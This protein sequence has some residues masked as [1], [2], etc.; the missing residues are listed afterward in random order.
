VIQSPAAIDYHSA[1]LHMVDSQVR[2]NKVTDPAIIEAMLAV[3]RERFVP[4]SLRGIAY[5][6]D[7][8]PLGGGRYLMEPMVFGRLLQM[9]A[10]G[11]NDVVLD[12][13]CGP[14]YASAVM[15]RLAREVV[16]LEEDAALARQAAGLVAEL[17]LRNV[18]VVEGRLAAGYAARAPYDVIL[19]NGAVAAV[20]AEFV[21][22][23]ADGGRLIAVVKAKSGMGGA[24][25][26][27]RAGNA[28]GQRILFD[29]ATPLLPG[30]A[31]PPGFEF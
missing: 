14:G 11:R 16:A 8:I 27:T 24:V 30:F 25:L 19:V 17:A 3:A 9:A 1:R 10:I 26:M 29:A 7:D 23:L 22:Q 2:P 28:F 5:I 4:S 6:D 18:A 13:G 31:A 20:P 12:V 21:G 15:A